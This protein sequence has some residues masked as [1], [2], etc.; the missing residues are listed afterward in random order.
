MYPINPPKFIGQY[1]EA[2]ALSKARIKVLEGYEP[3][4]EQKGPHAFNVL[5][6]DKQDSVLPP[7]QAHVRPEVKVVYLNPQPKK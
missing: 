6:T 3:R 4:I 1:P 2:I 7:G 5:V